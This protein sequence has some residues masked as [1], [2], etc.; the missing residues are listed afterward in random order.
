MPTQ[1]VVQQGECLSSIAKRYGL[2]DYRT[3]YDDPA[4]ADFKQLRPNP[5]LIYPGDVLVIPI[6]R[7][8]SFTLATG[9]EHKFVVKRPAAQLSLQIEVAAQHHYRLVVGDRTFTGQTDGQSPIVHPIPPDAGSGRIELWP[10]SS[11][12]QQAEQGLFG[13]DLQLGALDP[14]EELSGVQ[15]RLANL[16]YYNGPVDGEPG[17]DL[18]LAVARFQGDQGLPITGD[19][20]DD[21]RAALR[22]RH[23]GD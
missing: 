14:I 6:T 13:W 19:V 17:D 2:A 7:P 8:P 12:N 20:D 18:Q 11:G 1:H 21:T 15:S 3:I 23:D 4:N 9:K 5:N 16:G 10:A 22:T